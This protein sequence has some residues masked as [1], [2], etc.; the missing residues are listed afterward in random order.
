MVY[1]IDGATE[2]DEQNILSGMRRVLE[3]NG[4]GSFVVKR[5]VIAGRVGETS[6]PL[7]NAV[8]KVLMLIEFP[9]GVCHLTVRD[10]A[11]TF[12]KELENG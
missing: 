6:G 8:F 11:Y 2:F 4:P 3:N 12:L 9:D 5:V 1:F 7:E 10:F